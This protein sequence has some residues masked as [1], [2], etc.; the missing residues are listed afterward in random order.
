MD[1]R[2]IFEARR[3]RAEVLEIL[4]LELTK[5]PESSFIYRGDCPFC[6]WKES[7]F[8]RANKGAFRCDNPECIA[9]HPPKKPRR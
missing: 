1:L 9:H 3:Q 6:K 2:A 7:F 4:Y 5:V 8:V